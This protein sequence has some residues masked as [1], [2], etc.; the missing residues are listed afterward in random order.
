MNKYNRKLFVTDSLIRRNLTNES[1]KEENLL[2]DVNG[3]GKLGNSQYLTSVKAFVDFIAARVTTTA[4]K[5]A[6]RDEGIL[7]SSTLASLNFIGPGIT[8]SADIGNDWINI[9]VLAD[10]R[11]ATYDPT[12]SGSVLLADN[13]K[14]MDTAGANKYYGTDALGVVGIHPLSALSQTIYDGVDTKANILLLDP[15]ANLGSV[16]WASDT[17]QDIRAVNSDAHGDIWQVF[18]PL[19]YDGSKDTWSTPSTADGHS[20]Q[21]GEESFVSARNV[22]LGATELN[23]RVFIVNGQ[24]ATNELIGKATQAVSGDLSNESV[25]GINT[26]DAANGEQTKITIFGRV[27]NVNTT[28]WALGTELY[29]SATT[30]GLMVSTMP[31]TNAYIIGYVRKSH[32]TDGII[33]VTAFRAIDNSLVTSVVGSLRSNFTADLTVAPDPAPPNGFYLAKSADTGTI[34]E[35]SESIIVSSNQKL[36]L[37]KDHVTT[38]LLTE[39]TIELGNLDAQI[40]YQVTGGQSEKK[41]YI[42]I[43]RAQLTGAPIDVPNTLAVGDL[44]VR[45]ITV[46]ESPLTD[47]VNGSKQ[48]IALTGH[49]PQ[50]VIIPVG[51]RLRYHILVE[52]DSAEGGDATFTIYY[53]SDNDT[54]TF[55]PEIFGLGSLSNVEINSPTHDQILRF[56]AADGL[57][58]NKTLV[59]AGGGGSL[60]VVD[61]I[62]ARDALVVSEGDQ[63]FVKDATA[64]PLVGK[65]IWAMYVYT[66]TWVLNSSEDDVL[67]NSIN[68]DGIVTSSAWGDIPAG[69]DVSTLRDRAITSLLDQALFATLD[70]TIAA[71]LSLSISGLNAQSV[72][73]GTAFTPSLNGT[74]NQGDIDNGDG[75]AGPE[76]VGLPNTWRF[77][78]PN[79]TTSTTVV[80][81]ALVENHVFGNFNVIKGSNLWSV[82]TDYDAGAGVY[83]DS[84]GNPS[85]ILDASRVLGT[86]AKNS[87]NVQ[88][89]YGF[90]YG[91]GVTPINTS[92]VRNGTLVLL[93]SSD[94]GTFDFTLL[95]ASTDMWFSIIGAPSYT[96]TQDPNG[97][98][99]D[100]TGLFVDT[101]FNVEDA[102][103]ALNAYQTSGAYYGAAGHGDLLIRVTIL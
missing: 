77:K 54:R 76:L 90:F 52:K 31:T 43:Y 66:T 62:A 78:Y 94:K 79:G 32:A 27:H 34:A 4:G 18:G 98:P 23:P 35:A 68:P 17:K 103:G 102:V 38:Q 73:V 8:A 29:P 13:I 9:Q 74:F 97:L 92:E 49:V 20:I 81:A 85:T 86:I 45:P 101:S 42:E 37:L 14:G 15:T 58:K 2:I 50:D 44:G 41:F 25:F 53:G 83:L 89:F 30:P 91:F 47:P 60:D 39:L 67:F 7:L 46:L 56:D 12:S 51:N 28:A 11:K 1:I 88:G 99:V 48:L 65:A 55:I 5:W 70:P 22:S 63:A 59:D 80:S 61:D 71:N 6:I 95:D 69:T 40:E 87:A 84:K 19:E 16:W 10:M 93:N 21:V 3:S 72:E 57:W 36:P 100:I 96:V 75:S 24:D 26:V 82:E 33:E 64:D